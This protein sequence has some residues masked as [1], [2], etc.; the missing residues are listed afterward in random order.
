MKGVSTEKNAITDEAE[1]RLMAFIENDKRL[2]LENLIRCYIRYS[3]EKNIKMECH[4]RSVLLE[5]V[6]FMANLYLPEY[7]HKNLYMFSYLLGFHGEPVPL[8]EKIVETHTQKF[9]AYAIPRRAGK[10][11]NICL[12][13]ALILVC[14]PGENV[15]YMCDKVPLQKKMNADIQDI[16]GDVYRLANTFMQGSPTIRANETGIVFQWPKH[17]PSRLEV[18]CLHNSQVG[19][20]TGN[21]SWLVTKA[22]IDIEAW[23]MFPTMP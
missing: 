9:A 21:R 19:C 3:E 12:V 4:Q 8:L 20:H 2:W 18:I 16:V 5:V 11:F 1:N 14:L 23:N 13:I 22:L 15:A 7:R 6:L 10:S 17:K